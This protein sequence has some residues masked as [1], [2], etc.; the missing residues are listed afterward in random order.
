MA[1]ID[2]L[3]TKIELN[4]AGFTYSDEELELVINGN[5]TGTYTLPVEIDRNQIPVKYIDGF[6]TLFGNVLR[7]KQYKDLSYNEL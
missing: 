4:P 2:D 1:L 3:K 6:N 7:E 5:L